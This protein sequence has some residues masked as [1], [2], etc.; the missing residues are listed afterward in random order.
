MYG[1]KVGHQDYKVTEKII[2]NDKFQSKSL[3]STSREFND[4]SDA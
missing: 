1:S 2:K 4:D 3:R